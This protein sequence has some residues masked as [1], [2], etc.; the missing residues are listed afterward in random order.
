L[1]KWGWELLLE[2]LAGGEVFDEIA[3]GGEEVV[4][5]QIFELDPLDL[6][7][8]AVFDLAGE[9]F[10][11]EELEIDGA[12]VA[13]VVADVGDPG[14][15]LSGDTELLIELAGEGLLGTFAGLDLAAGKLPLQGHGLVGAPLADEHLAG[16]DHQSG[17]HQTK[18]RRSGPGL[19]VWLTVFHTL[20]VI[21]GRRQTV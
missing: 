9:L 21:A 14:A 11:G 6:L 16:P 17:C 20:S 4:A 2:Q 18:R 15:D 13:V 10:D 12:A 8:D 19:G 5:G 3:V 1:G 7:E